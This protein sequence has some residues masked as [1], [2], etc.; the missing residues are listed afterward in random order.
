MMRETPSQD[1]RG[2]DSDVTDLS[3]GVGSPLL[4]SR[5]VRET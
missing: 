3:L 1:R 4:P 2:Q 5:L